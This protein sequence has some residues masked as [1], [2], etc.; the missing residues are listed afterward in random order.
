MPCSPPIVLFSSSHTSTPH[1]AHVVDNHDKETSEAKEPL[2]LAD[3]KMFSAHNK[4]FGSYI[5]PMLA[6]CRINPIKVCF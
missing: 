3:F 4:S 2:I 5:P 1:D 6:Y